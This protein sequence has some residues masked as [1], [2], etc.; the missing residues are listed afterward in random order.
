M[1]K[2]DLSARIGATEWKSEIGGVCLYRRMPCAGCGAI[3]IYRQDECTYD[4]ACV[5]DI[6]VD[7]VY[8]QVARL[9]DEKHDLADAASLTQS[10]IGNAA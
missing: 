10:I 9:V 3:P 6:S 4:I 1:A 7:E 2:L 8:E 5:K